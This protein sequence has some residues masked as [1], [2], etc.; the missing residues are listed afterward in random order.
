MEQSWYL[1]KKKGIKLVAA[2]GPFKLKD[3]DPNLAKIS[4]QV[5][6]K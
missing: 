6:N 5:T 4:Q 2:L 1:P 3:L